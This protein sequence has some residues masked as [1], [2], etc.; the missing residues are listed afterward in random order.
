MKRVFMA[1]TL[2]AIPLFAELSVD[3]IDQMVE[4]IQGKRQ[5]KV[6][7]DFEKVISPFVTVV[8]EENSTKSVIK[9]MAQQVNFKLSAIIND[10]AKINGQWV[11]EGESIQGYTVEKVEENHV[12]LK[13][14]DRTVEL[15]LPNLKKNNLLQISEG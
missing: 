5:S 13:K 8:H 12:V 2:L 4:Q 9:M 14:A 11:K 7:V 3:R 10:S 1:T 6:K 15:F